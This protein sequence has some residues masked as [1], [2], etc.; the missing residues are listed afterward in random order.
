MFRPQCSY[1]ITLSGAEPAMEVATRAIMEDQSFE[2]DF[3]MEIDEH[4]GDRN[5]ELKRGTTEEVSEFYDILAG[6]AEA[7]PEVDIRGEE[8]DEETH[9]YHRLFLFKD[10]KV[11]D[12]KH[13]RNLCPEEYDSITVSHCVQVL[14]EAGFDDAVKLLE[15]K[16]II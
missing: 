1:W 14:K 12:V 8:I 7:N 15:E 3:K 11:T 10:G 2:G 16:V 4:T 5:F 13:G 6:I 9:G